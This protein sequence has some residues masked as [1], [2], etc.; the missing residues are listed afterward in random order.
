MSDFHEVVVFA[1]I[2]DT[3]HMDFLLGRSCATAASASF[4]PERHSA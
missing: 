2:L 3:G 1:E 4:E